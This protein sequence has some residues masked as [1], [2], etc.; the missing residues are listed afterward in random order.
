MNNEI[1]FDFMLLNVTNFAYK[2]YIKRTSLW[3]KLY[4]LVLVFARLEFPSLIYANFSEHLKAAVE[5][6]RKKL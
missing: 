2:F 1:D 4:V 3:I 5:L 6:P